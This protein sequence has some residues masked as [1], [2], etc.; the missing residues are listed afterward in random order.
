MNAYIQ[1]Y[2]RHTQKQIWK[3]Q[4]GRDVVKKIWKLKRKK[5]G[6]RENKT[7]KKGIFESAI[8]TATIS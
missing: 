2:K 1:S 3:Y 5:V 7:E 8:K 6:K 4:R